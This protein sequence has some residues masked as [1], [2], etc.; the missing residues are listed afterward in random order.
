[1]F[2]NYFFAFPPGEDEVPVFLHPTGILSTCSLDRL[3]S[4]DFVNRRTHQ[5]PFRAFFSSDEP[6]TYI[7]AGSTILK[8]IEQYKE[9]GVYLTIFRMVHANDCYEEEEEVRETKRTRC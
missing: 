5:D 7:I 6:E 8:A 9:G 3:A 2:E 4:F 1:M